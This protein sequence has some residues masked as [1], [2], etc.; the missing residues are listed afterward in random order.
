M[1]EAQVSPDGRLPFSLRDLSAG[2]GLAQQPLEGDLDRYDRGG[3]REGEG[4]DPSLTP[5]GPVILAGRLQVPPPAGGAQ[6]GGAG[7]GLLAGPGHAYLSSGRSVYR[8]DGSNVRPAGRPGGGGPGLQRHPQLPGQPGRAPLVP[9]L[10]LR[11]AARYSATGGDDWFP[12]GGAGRAGNGA[13]NSVVQ[14]D[15]EAV[16][17]VRSPRV[18]DAMVCT[19]DDGGPPPPSPGSID[20]IGDL[21]IPITRLMVFD[22]RIVVLKNHEGLFLI[23]ERPALDGGGGLPRVAG[24]RASTPGG[25]ASGGACCG[26][27]PA[28]GCTPS[29]PGWGCRRWAPRRRKPRV[30]PPGRP[31]AP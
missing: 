9:A 29:A 3:R 19:F 21:R 23:T 25:P 26:Y 27:P 1:G 4:V 31:G 6:A 28:T 14:L 18:G 30:S 20:P 8:F 2:A 24:R 11:G 13:I 7:G 10:R 22:G 12:V 15:G 16:A 17:A 5:T